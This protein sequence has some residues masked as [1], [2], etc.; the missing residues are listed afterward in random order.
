MEQTL[1]L[2][3]KR[4]LLQRGKQR[5]QRGQGVVVG[6]FEGFDGGD[7][8]GE[9]LLEG[10]GGEWYFHSL[11]LFSCQM[12]DGCRSNVISKPTSLG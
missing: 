4:P 8:G 5:I 9:G 3:R 12:S 1:Q 7:A 2:P 10:E 11:Q 6:G